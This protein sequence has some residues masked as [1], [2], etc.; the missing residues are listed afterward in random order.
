M[1]YVIP[2]FEQYT[3]DESLVV[4]NSQGK[5]LAVKRHFNQYTVKLCKDG[6]GYNFPIDHLFIRAIFACAD[7]KIKRIRKDYQFD[8][9]NFEIEFASPEA[10]KAIQDYNTQQYNKSCEEFYRK[11]GGDQ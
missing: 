2:E 10:I 9:N 8:L 7:I 5:K 3:I 11:L 6:K 1:R 4:R